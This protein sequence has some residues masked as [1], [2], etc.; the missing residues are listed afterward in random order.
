MDRA[1]T[2]DAIDL[3]SGRFLVATSS[4]VASLDAPVATCPGW[5]VAHLVNHLGAIYSRVTLV[6]SSLRTVAPDRSELPAAPTGEAILRWF[7]EQQAAMLRALET[8]DDDTRVWNFTRESPG[9]ASFWA[10]RMTHETLI[11]RVDVEL[12]LGFIPAPPVPAV[13]TDTVTEFLELFVP[14][15]RDRLEGDLA[16][17]IHLDA[18]DV[19]S[20]EWTLDPRSGQFSVSRGGEKADVTLR[21]SAFELACWIWGRRPTEQ[22][23]VVGD[24]GIADAF[25]KVVRT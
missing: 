8:T 14:R 5:D 25:Q 1:T 13:A 10:R 24:P 18:T 9:P 19:P 21:G 6:L 3:E 23:H 17:P 22:L 15:F 7:A 4:G 12:A 11:H 2:L 20:G 16:G